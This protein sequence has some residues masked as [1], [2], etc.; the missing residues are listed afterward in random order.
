M[1]CPN[2]EWVVIAIFINSGTLLYTF[3]QLKAHWLDDM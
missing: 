1:G 2:G 3:R